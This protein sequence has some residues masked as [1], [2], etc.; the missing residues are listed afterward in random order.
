M[1][2]KVIWTK[3]AKI[4]RQNILEY[5]AER[6]GNKKYCH[7]ISSIVRNRIQ[8]IDKFVYLGKETDFGDVRVTSAGHFSLFY[9]VLADKIIIMSLWDNRQDPDKLV[10]IVKFKVPS[11]ITPL[12]SSPSLP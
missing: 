6:N 11:S 3:T 8:F 7:K 4:Q 10:D 12:T 1:V 9:R 5:W 2:K